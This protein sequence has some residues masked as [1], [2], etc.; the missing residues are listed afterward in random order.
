MTHRAGLLLAVLMMATLLMTFGMTAR[1]QDS[2]ARA[3]C[4]TQTGLR[5]DGAGCSQGAPGLDAQAAQTGTGDA[6]NL[7]RLNSPA[8][9][10]AEDER[11]RAERGEARSAQRT[12]RRKPQP[13]TEYEALVE[14][15]TGRRLPIYGQSLF[16]EPPST[17]A[18]LEGAPVPDDYIVGPGDELQ[19]RIWG[20][21]NAD[22]RV[23]VDRAGEIYIPKVGELS[24]A[25]VRASQLD[26]RLHD[27]VGRLFRNF[28]LTVSL[29]RIRSIEVYVVG[30]AREPGT[31]TVSSL[32]TLVN[33]IFASGGPSAAGSLR[34]IQV[35]REGRT[36]AHLDLY[37]LLVKGDKS[38][39]V[40]LQAGDVIYY[41]PAG[42]MA[43]VTGSVKA[44]AI[45]ELKAGER[46]EEL[47]NDAG[48][49]ATTADSE[50][51]TVERLLGKE[52]L[53]GPQRG[54][55]ATAELSDARTV[56]E[57]P[58]DAASRGLK[59]RDGDIV[60][61]LGAV[62]R[63][64]Q[65]VTL[66]GSVVRPGDYPWHV[67]MKVRDL[68]PDAQSLLTRE[69][70]MRRLSAGRREE[71]TRGEGS[72][73]R[74]ERGSA[75]TSGEMA[76]SGAAG[77]THAAG[78]DEA[79]NNE[80]EAAGQGRA[81]ENLTEEL[82]R[83]T[84]EINWSYAIIQRV[85]PVDLSSRLVPF[86]LAR[87]VLAGDAANNLTLEPGDIVTIFSQA[88]LRV[89]LGE[90]TRY[91]RVEG[92]VRRPGVYQVAAGEGLREVLE[93]A[94]GLTGNAYAYGTQLTRESARREQQKSLDEL[95]R[96]LEAEL[97]RASA[98]DAA[99]GGEDALLIRE[100]QSAQEGMIAQLRAA[101]ASGRVVLNLSPAA[102]S[103]GAFPELEMEDNDQVTVP[104]R[105]STVSVMGMVYNA[106]S[107]VYV[108]RRTVG[109]YL[110]LAGRG[111]VDAD[112]RHA[113]VLHADGSV[114]ASTAVNGVFSG[115]RFAGLRMR[116]GDQ[117]VVPSRVRSGGL[118]RGLRD[119]T[120]I[121]S[122]L[123]LTGAAVA[124]LR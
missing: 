26:A 92:E 115:D 25:G 44:P 116:P 95:A 107:F 53:L 60:K 2:A 123:A 39:D 75:G 30:Q 96:S 45:Y 64:E 11:S 28:S 119:W 106:G 89:P 124:I 1:A 91:V 78:T 101:T 99:R 51:V 110:K 18:P 66:R 58:L 42:A 19:V 14:K 6:V 86:D 20:Q 87:A 74:G 15:V 85:N 94:G 118:L 122:Q 104:A 57:F 7:P 62:P 38:G 12:A 34:D 76:E 100:R 63:L 120:Q 31:Y 113:F 102:N 41:P 33:A 80:A 50:R 98:G 37:E 48:G 23:T 9:R 21:L 121:S 17:F 35:Q 52:R 83:T 67:G 8:A 56:M 73:L 4:D 59:L 46:L 68:I 61:V 79:R 69:Y 10:G 111:R 84:P 90:R 65:S 27:E 43:A 81:G 40:R 108:A 5:G 36:V 55:A 88:D 16:V 112:M 77:S 54:T 47:L 70:W 117:I 72:G 105:P 97:R 32:S 13:R 49:L 22:L 29:G 103:L 114:T 3:D 71:T 24:V 82:H 109:D 93:R